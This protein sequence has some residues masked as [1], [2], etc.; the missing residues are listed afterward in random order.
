MPRPGGRE[1]KRKVLRLL[2]SGR[3]EEVL[4]SLCRMPARRIVNPLFGLLLSTEPVIRW[5]AVRALGAVTARMAADDME[6]ARVI[7]RRFMW[8]LNDES[9]G[10]GWG[11]P[12]AMG[13][14]MA[15]GGRLAREF[16]PILVSYIREDGN[17][18]EYPPLQEGVL[19]G[20]A[21]LAGVRPE[22]FPGISPY[23]LPF[24]SAGRPGL[25]GLAAWVAGRLGARDLSGALEGLLVDAGPFE[26][27]RDGL[28]AP[29]TVGTLALEAMARLK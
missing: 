11:C 14:A 19:W 29:V 13:E 10:I 24:L 7:M 16:S 8:Q 28:L 26:L 1:I 2:E 4:D 23:L 20:L 6:S 17:Y 22:V 5:G 15:R 18:L 3:P 25:R 21:R 27:F 12:E 9:G